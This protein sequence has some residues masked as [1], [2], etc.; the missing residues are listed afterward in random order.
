VYLKNTRAGQAMMKRTI[1][2]Q[3]ECELLSDQVFQYLSQPR[4]SPDGTRI[5]LGGS[6][7]PGAQPTACGGDN[8]P[9]PSGSLPALDLLTWLGPSVAYA[10]GLPADIYTLGIDGNNLMRVADI[11]DDDPT[12]AWS[13]DGARQAIFGI[14]A[15]YIVDSK[16][17]PPSKLV[18][19]G[20]YGGLDWTR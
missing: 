12:V 3:N 13:P 2:Q 7:E 9:K 6:G 5:A 17:G 1:G 15:L 18:E 4:I 11:K 19:Q 8:R 14:A 10:H 16:G 20:G